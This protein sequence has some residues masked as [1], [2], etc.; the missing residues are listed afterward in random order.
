[1]VEYILLNVLL[2]FTYIYYFQKIKHC[3]HMLQLESYMN[4]RYKTWLNKNKIVAVVNNLLTLFV[5]TNFF[6][7]L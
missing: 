7:S 4:V 3:I 2:V 5:Y 6:F 1:M